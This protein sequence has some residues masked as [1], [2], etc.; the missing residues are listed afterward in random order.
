[1]H[2]PRARNDICF[3]NFIRI[4]LEQFSR[5]VVYSQAVYANA[6]DK[7]SNLTSSYVVAVDTCRRELLCTTN[8]IVTITEVYAVVH[9]VVSHLA[10]T[11][12]LRT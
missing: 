4:S 7:A 11:Y 6:F 2:K 10:D 1:M 12:S 8:A 5:V 3:T 9:F